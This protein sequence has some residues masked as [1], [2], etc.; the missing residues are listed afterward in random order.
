MDCSKRCDAPHSLF[1][2]YASG[3]DFK[4]SLQ[5]NLIA[6][7]MKISLDV[8]A[9]LPTNYQDCHVKLALNKTTYLFSADTNFMYLRSLS[10]IMPAVTKGYDTDIDNLRGFFRVLAMRVD[11]LGS[12]ILADYFHTYGTGVFLGLDK[13][14][15]TYQAEQGRE[16][17]LEIIENCKSLFAIVQS[18][19]ESGL[20]QE[21]ISGYLSEPCCAAFFKPFTR[22]AAHM[23]P[24][25]SFPR[26]EKWVYA[27]WKVGLDVTEPIISALDASHESHKTFCKEL[28]KIDGLEIIY[29]EL[30][31]TLLEIESSGKNL[32]ASFHFKDAEISPIV[33]NTLKKL[34]NNIKRSQNGNIKNILHTLCV[35]MMN[36]VGPYL[37][38]ISPYNQWAS[39]VTAPCQAID[40]VWCPSLPFYGVGEKEMQECVVQIW[41]QVDDFHVKDFRKDKL[42]LLK[43]AE[44]VLTQLFTSGKKTQPFISSWILCF[45]KELLELELF[46]S[47]KEEVESKGLQDHIQVYPFVLQALTD[48]ALCIT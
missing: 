47:L 17:T 35:Q 29:L 32:E 43:C 8:I 34:V 45:Y 4:D 25:S 23:K 27:C 37:P 10:G 6:E 2:R 11:L 42:T 22:S 36:T 18:V 13:L 5:V 30:L 41:L 15:G 26:I 14:S 33:M 40:S 39:F 1:E 12:T 20:S 21:L 3:I 16:K 38:F 9:G 24:Y 44:G 19:C 46:K 7:K 31:A 28:L 48:K